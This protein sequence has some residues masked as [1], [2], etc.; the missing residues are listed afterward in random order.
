MAL[1]NENRLETRVGNV[2]LYGKPHS[3]SA[4]FVVLLRVV[5]GGMILFAGLGKYA[6][7]PGGDAFN[8]AGYLGNVD[9]ASPVSGLYGAMA[10]NAAL[11]DVVNVI[12]PLT[13][14][15]IGVALI[16]GGLVRLAALGGA[17]QMFAFYLGGMEGQWLAAFDSTL[18]YA[19][20][21]LTLGALAAGRILGADA[22]IEQLNVGGEPLVER[23]PKLRYILG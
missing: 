11:M 7:V 6:F 15:L 5:M 1:E 9:A 14:V 22:Y 17:L 16:V 23:F 8:A 19:I 13:Q 18:I 3:L 10:A 2:T 20:V 21:F 4:L 12:I